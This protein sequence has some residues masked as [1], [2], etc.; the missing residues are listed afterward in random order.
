M[1]CHRIRGI[2]PE[3]KESS[4]LT[5]HCISFFCCHTGELSFFFGGGGEEGIFSF[6]TELQ[7][8]FPNNERGEFCKCDEYCGR[9]LV[10]VFRSR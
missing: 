7:G 6:R 8:S 5:L 10:F 3:E 4:L 2:R 1:R 9:S